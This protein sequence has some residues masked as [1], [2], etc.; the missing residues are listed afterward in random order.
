MTLT[1]ERASILN[2]LGEYRGKQNLFSKQTPETLRSLQQAAIIE[3]S[4]S[5][6]R[7][8]ALALKSAAPHNRSEQEIPGYRDDL[9]LIHESA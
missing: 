5:S 3:S 1:V 2:R 6:N 4:E 9:A 8:E 7:I